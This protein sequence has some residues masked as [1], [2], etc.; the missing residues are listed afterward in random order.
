MAM[1]YH[2]NSHPAIA[3]STS[4]PER[5]VLLACDTVGEFAAVSTNPKNRMKYGFW[6]NTY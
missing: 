5:I 1:T 3:S 6:G 2:Q 4:S